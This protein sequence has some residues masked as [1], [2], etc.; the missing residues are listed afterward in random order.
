MELIKHSRRGSAALGA[1]RT[2]LL[3]GGDVLAF[4]AFSALGRRSHGAAAGLDAFAQIAETAA[5]FAAGWLLA[6]PLLGA[7]KP[8]V[9]AHPRAMLS[10]TALSWLV[11]LPIGLLLR[12]LVRQ[13]GIPLSFAITTLLVLMVLL[14]G[15]RGAFAWL[16]RRREGEHGN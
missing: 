7:F 8:D 15:W 2:A 14:C 5:P 11:A 9:V 13:S 16:A 4:L 6:A 1:W 3:V 12:A 10:R